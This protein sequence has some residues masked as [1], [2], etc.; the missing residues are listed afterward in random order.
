M[1][2]APARVDA[3]S[4]LEEAPIDLLSVRENTQGLLLAALDKIDGAK[5]LVLDPAIIGPIGAVCPVSVL[6]EHGVANIFQLTEELFENEGASSAETCVYIT[7][8]KQEHTRIFAAHVADHAD[9]NFALFFVP[10]RSVPCEKILE[11]ADIMDRLVIP[12]AQVE[13]D[14]IPFDKDLL[15]LGMDSYFRELYLEQ[16][17]TPLYYL[18]QAL[19]KLQDTFGVIPSIKTKGA[20]A[21]KVKNI[22]VRMRREQGEGPRPTANCGIDSLIILDRSVDLVTPMLSQLTYEGLIDE[23]LGIANA[24]VELDPETAG[25]EVPKGRKAR[26]TKFPLN[27]NDEFYNDI[28]DL[29]FGVVHTA[30]SRQARALQ[31]KEE[32]RHDAHSVSQIKDFVKT[33]GSLQADKKSL[34]VHV[35]IST[36]INKSTL[37]DDTGN[38]IQRVQRE[39]ALVAG[40]DLSACREYLEESI[41]NKEPLLKVL[42]LLCLYSLTTDG[43]K[44][45]DFDFYR[46]E[47]MQTYGYPVLFAMNNLEKVGLFHVRGAPVACPNGNWAKCLRACRLVVEDLNEL[48]PKDISY[49]YSSYAPL[50]V[51]LVQLAY[52]TDEGN[53]FNEQRQA[54]GWGGLDDVLPGEASDEATQDEGV[55]AVGVRPAG[56]KKA[57]TMVVFIGG[58]TYAEISALRFMSKHDTERQYVVATTK[59]INGDTMLDGLLEKVDGLQMDRTNWTRD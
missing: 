30:I 2:A 14:M 57:V 4:T 52:R 13:M 58:V 7:R 53:P 26:P 56:S 18:A 35:N 10:R 38:F 15:A 42:R 21:Q 36:Q 43:M 47:M 16:D 55:A 9:K 24:T 1:A 20:F 34:A 28:R 33:M 12:V 51:R 45:R 29:N 39:Q 31:Q 48:K 5:V 41:F 17:T 11:D 22:M 49:V 46:R 44:Q 25:I 54:P 37:A 6:K 32:A 59:F 3:R 23:Q 50:S 27:S 19:M 8:A 40:D